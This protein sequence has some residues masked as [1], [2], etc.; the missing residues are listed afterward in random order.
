MNRNKILL[1]ATAVLGLCGATLAQ[2]GGSWRAASNT[3]K[4]ITGDIAISDPK[5]WINFTSFTIA[6]IR[7]LKEPEESSLF[8]DSVDAAGS[9]SLYRTNIPS[10]KKFLHKNTLCGTDDTQWVATY[11]SGRQLQVAFFSGNDM[12]VFTPE[13]IANSTNLCGT[14]MYYR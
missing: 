6:R 14:Y 1:C 10:V 11:V 9:G 12:P 7:P 5:L 13:A 2:E 8:G 3:A 4:S